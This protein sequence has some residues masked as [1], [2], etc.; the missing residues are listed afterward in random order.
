M[1][2]LQQLVAL[3]V[4]ALAYRAYRARF[5]DLPLHM[6]TA[7]YVTNQTVR[8]TRYRPFRGWNA[9]FSGGGRLL[10]EFV[11]SSL[12]L[13]F[14]ARGYAV[15][16]RALYSWLAFIAA[17]MTGLVAQQW[18]ARPFA[19]WIAAL[20]T[21]ALLAEV[22][23]GGYFE[24]AEAF[25]L[26]MQ[27]SAVAIALFGLDRHD[28]VLECVA[29]VIV[30]LDVVLVKLTSAFGALSLSIA[31]VIANRSMTLP[32]L[33]IAGVSIGLYLALARRSGRP[34]RELLQAMRRHEQY[35]RRNYNV[36]KLPIVKLGFASKLMCHNLALPALA[37]LGVLRL[38]SSLH[39]GDRDRTA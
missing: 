3:V 22:Q 1:P 32:A 28:T 25:E 36:G 17:T 26:A 38:T 33:I 4:F 23:Y 20:I 15:R 6:D 9:L 18:F 10:P 2:S 35:V 39:V 30:W 12:F 31:L 27:T 21:A 8:R 16:F 14:G 34:I 19:F 29:L 11:H 7:F 37:L 13:R 24:S 5:A